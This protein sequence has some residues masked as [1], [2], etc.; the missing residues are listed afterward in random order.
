VTRVF[1]DQERCYGHARCAE[2][3]PHLFTLDA[4]GFAKATDDELTEAD[5]ALARRAH[6]SCPEQA[7]TVRP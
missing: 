2:A 3:A 1:V 5:E 7:I 6:L 4:Q